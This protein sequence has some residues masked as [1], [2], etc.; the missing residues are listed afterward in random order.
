[1]PAA[2]EKNSHISQ[3]RVILFVFIGCWAA[4]FAVMGFTLFRLYELNAALEQNF[5][6]LREELEISFADQN[7][8]L[9]EEHAAAVEIIQTDI[10]NGLDRTLRSIDNTAYRVRQIEQVYGDLLAEQKKKTLESLYNEEEPQTWI[11]EAEGLFG[12][13]RYRQAYELYARASDTQPDNQEAR[14]YRL[15]SLFLVNRSDRSQYRVIRSGLAQLERNG[16]TR[17]EI[18]EVLSY[19]EAEEGGKAPEEP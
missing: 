9:A 6:E 11:K 1:M 16:Y 12:S 18:G 7:A 4:G 17:P 5:K 2:H 3:I 10:Q 13:G 19:I 15:Y 8:H 14:F